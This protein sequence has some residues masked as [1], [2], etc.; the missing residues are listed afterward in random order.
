M[1]VVVVYL[2]VCVFVIMVMYESVG[3]SLR[4]R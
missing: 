2:C 1:C 3:F 4:V